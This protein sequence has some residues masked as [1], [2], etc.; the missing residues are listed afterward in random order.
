MRSVLLYACLLNITSNTIACLATP[1]QYKLPAATRHVNSDNGSYAIYSDEDSDDSFMGNIYDV[2][3]GGF[4]DEAQVL[5]RR[6]TCPECGDN[7]FLEDL[8][9]CTTCDHVA[10]KTPQQSQSQTSSQEQNSSQSPARDQ[11]DPNVKHKK[12]RGKMPRPEGKKELSRLRCKRYRERKGDAFREM[13]SRWRKNHPDY[14]K[15]QQQAW[16]KR[17]PERLKIYRQTWRKKQM[18]PLKRYKKG[19]KLDGERSSSEAKSRK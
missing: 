14:R 3:K 7:T 10:P 19:A 6:A 2:R 1:A 16:Q 8:R 4:T 18:R 17:N 12:R 15:G 9:Y 5:S 13:M 11:K